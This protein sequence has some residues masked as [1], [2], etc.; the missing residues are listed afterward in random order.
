MA[1][2]KSKDIKASLVKKGFRETRDSHHYLYVYYLDGKKTSI[3]TFVSHGSKDY[4]GALLGKM[5]NQLGL[6]KEQLHDLIKCPLSKEELYEI[7][8]KKEQ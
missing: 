6:T 5:K 7:Y 2:F 4:S 3:R 8:H 1:S